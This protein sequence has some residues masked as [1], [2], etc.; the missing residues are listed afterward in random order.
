MTECGGQNVQHTPA[1]IHGD[2]LGSGAVAASQ[3]VV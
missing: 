1:P 2:A 3:G